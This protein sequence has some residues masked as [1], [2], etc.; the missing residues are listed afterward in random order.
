MGAKAN[1]S[2]DIIP[3]YKNLKQISED[4]YTRNIQYTIYNTYDIIGYYIIYI[5]LME[6]K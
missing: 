6:K 1:A 5:Q 3:T 2:I 4:R